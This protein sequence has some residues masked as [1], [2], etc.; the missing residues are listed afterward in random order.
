MTFKNIISTILIF[1]G[2]LAYAV[3][4]VKMCTAI[5]VAILCVG[6]AITLAGFTL[7]IIGGFM[8]LS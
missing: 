5:T 7:I 8:A 2:F 4:L 3:G 1:F 6:T